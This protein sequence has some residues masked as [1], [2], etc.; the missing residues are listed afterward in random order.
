M[1]EQSVVYDTLMVSY[2]TGVKDFVTPKIVNLYAFILT[3]I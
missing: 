3:S 2:L 1:T